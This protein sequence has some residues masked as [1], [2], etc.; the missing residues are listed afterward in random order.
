MTGGPGSGA[1]PA[2]VD[3]VTFEVIRHRL[4]GITDEQAAKLSAISGSKNVTEMSD[5]NVG[6]Y[7]AD[8]SVATMGRTILFHSS[9]MAAMV[10]HVLADCAENPGI[11]PGDMFVV[12]NPWKGSVHGPDMAVVA[13]VFAGDELIFWSGALMHMSD[14]G[15][16]RQGGMGLDASECYQEGLLLPP[17]RLIEHGVV[18]GDVWNLI[19]SQT[20]T[21]PAM[22]LDLKGLIAANHAA[23]GGLAKLVARYGTATLLAVMSELI[24]LSEQRMRRRL[25]ELPDGTVETV[26][27]LEFN[28]ATGEVPQVALRL[29]KRGDSLVLDFSG[30]SAQTPDAR[31]CTWAGLMAGVSAA[32]LPTVGYDIPW[33]AGLYRPVE[34]ICPEGLICNARR[35]AAVS[36]NISGAVW[37]VEMTAVSA[38]SKLAA[39]SEEFCREA[40]ACPA[41]RPGGFTFF[42]VNQHGEPFTGSSLDNL[43]TGGGSYADHDG[44][45]A[46]GQHNIER[47]NISNI[48]ALELDFPLLY[49]WRGLARDGAGAGRHRGGLSVG[50]VCVPHKAGA[51]RFRGGHRFEVPDTAGAFGGYLGAQ[52]SRVLARGSDVQAWLAAGRVP[53][54][55]ALTAEFLAAASLPDVAEATRDDVLCTL[56]PAGGGWGD[57]VDRPVPDIAADLDAGA[58][59]AQAA[60]ALYGAVLDADGRPDA[61][62]T[63]ARRGEIRARRREWPPARRASSN[64]PGP[65][66]REV[67]LGDALEV[68][69][70]RGG[71]LWTRCACGHVLGP[72]EQN[73]RGYAGREAADPAQVGLALRVHESMELRR[74]SCPGCG[75]LLAAELYRRQEPDRHDI[76]LALVG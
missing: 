56:A 57:P 48:E 59:S 13:P 41:G 19:L 69:A 36:A 76:R 23:A 44:V 65:L 71:R 2:A 74:F 66:R 31:N 16:M 34:V 4:H 70:D 7:L 3:P 25:R 54:F 45:S 61:A 29:T 51:F 28:R 53:A 9:C 14:I 6:L 68:A 33:N 10:R 17:V 72:A 62:A 73:W 38:L 5:Y 49:L 35:P 47:L 64:P 37:E 8:G 30:S 46:Q 52:N 1:A 24:S 55:A 39:C 42:G 50:G 63:A 40:Q 32:L 58:I 75:R 26:G 21:A 11:G 60:E 20:R 12:N 18:R 22:T 43:A 15:G 27:Y 67:P